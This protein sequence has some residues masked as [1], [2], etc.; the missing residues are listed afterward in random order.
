MSELLTSVVVPCYNARPFIA[1]T[2]ESVLAQT[3]PA[4][5][6]VVVDDASTDGSWEIVQGF[7]DRVTAVRLA[8][9]QGGSHARNGGASLARGDFLMFLDADDLIAPDTIAHLVRAVRDRPESLAICRWQR[10]KI[11]A[12]EWVKVPTEVA[13]PVPGADPLRGWLEGSWV[14]PCAV[15]W[16]RDV[17]DRTGG[18]DESLTYNDDGDL[19]MRGFMQGVQLVAADGGEAWY[20]F[21]GVARVSVG[22]DLFAE[23]KVR[24]GMRVLDKLMHRLEEKGQL[25]EYAV[26]L[27][28]SFQW[29]AMLG[30]Q[31]G[32]PELARESLALGRR[33]AGRRLVSATLAGRV[34]ELLVGLE[35]KERI[36]QVL[37]RA[38]AVTRRRRNVLQ[39]A[40]TVERITSA[41]EGVLR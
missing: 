12:G 40:Q 38:G 35:E 34:L 24:S 13:F 28:T 39:R 8:K 16:R 2:L 41:D 14:P 18:W 11:I 20:R 15:L 3:Y 6:I 1:E 4:V 22:T 36:A 21:H 19:M 10:L 33:L 31:H 26:P 29:L 27:G 7:G 5:E 30:F 23:A 17:Y 32:H 9:N 37:G 25:T